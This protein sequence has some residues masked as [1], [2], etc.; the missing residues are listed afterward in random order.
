MHV[1]NELYSRACVTHK[2]RLPVFAWFSVVRN[3]SQVHVHVKD[4]QP[5]TMRCEEKHHQRDKYTR[6][7]LLFCFQSKR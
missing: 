7:G 1:A 2:S 5:L 4:G 3:V 6:L